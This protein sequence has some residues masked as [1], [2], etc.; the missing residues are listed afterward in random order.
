[1]IPGATVTLTSETRGTQLPDVATNASGDFTF[2]NVSPDRYSIQVSV[3][4][5]KTLKRGGIS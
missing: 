3:Q 2:P 4:G 1:M 5:F